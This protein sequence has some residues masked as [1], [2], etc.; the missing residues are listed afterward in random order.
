MIRR[1]GRISDGF[2]LDTSRIQP[3]HF[4]FI[5]LQNHPQHRTLNVLRLSRSLWGKRR[6]TCWRIPDR[7]VTARPRKRDARHACEQLGGQQRG[8][9]CVRAGRQVQQQV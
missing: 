6:I 1:T 4:R 2:S 5:F 7:S 3:A 8:T 9:M